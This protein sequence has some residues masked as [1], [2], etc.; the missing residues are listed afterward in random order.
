M[1][2]ESS[3]MTFG[4]LPA[5]WYCTVARERQVGGDGVRG[6]PFLSLVVDEGDEEDTGFRQTASLILV[7]DYCRVS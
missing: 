4:W 7:I 6:P 5:G 2:E 1:T 3:V